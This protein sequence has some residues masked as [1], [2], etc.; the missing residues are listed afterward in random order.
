MAVWLCRAG[1][2]GEY[3][4]KFIEQ[5]KIFLIGSVSIDLTGRTDMQELMKVISATYPTEPDG[6]VV[7][8]SVQARAFASKAKAGDWI[9]LPSRG[10]ERLLFIGE[11][12]GKYVYDKTKSEL[13]H[14]RE[15]TWKWGAWKREDFDE[16]I[17]RSVDA[18]D[19]FMMF[20]KLRQE[21]RIREIVGNGKAFSSL[22]LKKTASIN[23]PENEPIVESEESVS[24]EDIAEL[25]KMIA[26]LKKMIAESK[27]KAA[28][29]SNASNS[30]AEVSK[31]IEEVRETITL[32]RKE[33]LTEAAEVRKVITEVNDTLAEVKETIT[34]VKKATI[35]EAT[36]VKTVIA[37]VR[38]AIDRSDAASAKASAAAE[39]A[40]AA[41]ENSSATAKKAAAAAEKA[42]A[43]A[44]SSNATA[45]KAVA[46]AENSNATA[47]KAAAAAAESAAAK[48][49]GGNACGRNCVCYKENNAYYDIL[50]AR[51]C[52]R[53]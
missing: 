30:D 15:I 37:E 41:A 23:K 38:D 22:P 29:A 36:E 42:A 10:P 46:A 12:T 14:S 27:S 50:K 32:V 1:L 8:M 44:E 17:I 5:K 31:V 20:F 24:S 43:A 13:K 40:S 21:K 2:R 47:E 52:L 39:K 48:P 19:S 34:E 16:D 51:R 28:P 26:E 53:R 35:T 9:V 49:A 25:K 3:E 33:S 11:I 7:T 4:N 6:S 18:F 45:E